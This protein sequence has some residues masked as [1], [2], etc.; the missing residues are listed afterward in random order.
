MTFGHF[1]NWEQDV[2]LTTGN[3]PTVP[4]CSKEG[5]VLFFYAV[6]RVW[7]FFLCG[8]EGVVLCGL[9]SRD[10]IKL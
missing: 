3:R 7:S 4:R 5:V 8:K 9:R 2:I 6:K 10:V 1:D